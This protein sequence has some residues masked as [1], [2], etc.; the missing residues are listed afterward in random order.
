MTT[1]ETVAN[2]IYKTYEE[3]LH[4]CD[5]VGYSMKELT[6]V[7]IRKN[8][9][10]AQ[11]LTPESYLG[12]DATRTLLGVSFAL[13]RNSIRVLDFGGGGGYHYRLARHAL[14]KNCHIKW[15]VVETESMCEAGRSIENDNLKFFSDI[16]DAAD[17]LGYIDLVLSSSAIQYCPDPLTYLKRL[18]QVSAKYI[19][20]TR[21]PFFAGN[22]K[23]V[24][25]QSSMLSHNGPGALPEG[26]IDKEILYPISFIPLKQVEEIIQEK[27]SILF[28]VI[29]EPANLFIEGQPV[30]P[31]YGFFCELK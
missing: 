1:S 21:T 19:Y 12:A 10:I 11:S 3:A 6:E 17:D 30:N 20:I 5:G 27:Y 24:S 4:L 9:A 31:Y 25:I 26:Y 29:E 28:K 22:E 7:V 16:S 14:S 23:L 13:N 8:I 18:L 2:K 15:N